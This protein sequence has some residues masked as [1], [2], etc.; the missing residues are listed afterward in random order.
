MKIATGGSGGERETLPS[1][2]RGCKCATGFANK[3]LV[4]ACNRGA[5]MEA[6]SQGGTGAIGREEMEAVNE[7]V[8]V[9]NEAMVGIR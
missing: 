8:C 1:Q 4:G 5:G 6:T 7:S 3:A 9:E 2:G